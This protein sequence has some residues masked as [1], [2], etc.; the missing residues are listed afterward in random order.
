M[1]IEEQIK[2]CFIK[3]HENA[4]LP[5]RN[6]KEPLIGDAGYDVYAV[7][8]TC[9]PANSTANVPIGLEVGYIQPSY[10]IR[11]ESRSGMFFRHGITSFSGVLDTAYRGKLGIALINHTNMDYYVKNG[12]RVA[13]LV[14]YKLIEP[15]ISWTETKDE[16]N[17]GDKGFGSSGR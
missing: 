6:N 15:E 9:I 1:K 13:Q 14:V 17:R 12:D 3:S 2:I 7:E 8:D 16:T 11:I 10:W 4:R 5:E